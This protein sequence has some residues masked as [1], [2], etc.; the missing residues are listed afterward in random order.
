MQVG[1][2]YK[3]MEND[4]YAFNRSAYVLY[5][6]MEMMVMLCKKEKKNSQAKQCTHIELHM[7]FN[8]SGKYRKNGCEHRCGKRAIYI[9][10][11][12]AVANNLQL[13]EL[14]RFDRD[15]LKNKS[16]KVEWKKK[17]ELLL[18]PQHT[19]KRLCA[20]VVHPVVVLN[21]TIC[22]WPQKHQIFA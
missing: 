3:V 12:L 15:K 20:N 18:L 4:K 21:A 10:V 6:G 2:S 22:Q 8:W 13:I 5:H 7:Q 14:C 1:I 17:N 9:G 19:K 11:A 16:I